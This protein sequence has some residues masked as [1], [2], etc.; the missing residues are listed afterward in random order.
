MRVE[1][2]L[3]ASHMQEEMLEHLMNKALA[4]ESIK[5]LLRLSWAWPKRNGRA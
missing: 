1:L 3:F 2:E 5:L 4:P